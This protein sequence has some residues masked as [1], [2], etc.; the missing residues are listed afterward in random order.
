VDEVIN[1]LKRKLAS[2]I[3]EVVGLETQLSRVNASVVAL[4]SAI[5]RLEFPN[6]F[7]PAELEDGSSPPETNEEP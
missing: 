5:E 7:A 3:D 6:P 4:R 1:S 2:S